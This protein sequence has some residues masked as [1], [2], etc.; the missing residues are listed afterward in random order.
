MLTYAIVQWPEGNRVALLYEEIRHY[1]LAEIRQGHLKPGDR[2]PSEAAL[3][4]QF[5]VSR[6]T[7]KKALQT[8]QQDG[9]VTR[10]R[11]RGSFVSTDRSTAPPA[12]PAHRDDHQGP[13]SRH[14]RRI[15]FIAPDIDDIY[16][17]ELLRAIENACAELGYQLVFRRTVGDAR[18]ET[19]AIVDFAS[20]GI[21]GIIVFPIHGEFYN[22]E[23]LR[24]VLR[25]FPVVLV[26]RYLKGIAVSSVATD[27]FSAAHDLTS[28]LLD[29]DHREIGF[30]TAS[31]EHTSSIEDRWQG[32]LAALSERGLEGRRDQSLLTLSSTLPG[33]AFDE[34]MAADRERIRH[35]LGANPDLTA[36]IACEYPLAQLLDLE[37]RA[38]AELRP[39][40]T[41]A[42]FDSPPGRFGGSPYLHVRQRQ[43]EIGRVAV[44]LL[45][46]QFRDGG[47]PRHIAI[48]FDLI[49]PSPSQLI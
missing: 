41:I 46:E 21:D 44:D 6:I 42:C 16:G 2:L 29:Q 48:P 36:F 31:P 30:V 3:A 49:V 22:H 23:L 7:S 43:D 15:G 32:F 27:N 20:T 14:Q 18:I 10:S 26:D 13:G 47:A 25:G 8:L 37:L 24:L 28:A 39:E 35:F 33:T 5:K 12:E 17:A 40:V 11:G 9:I 38:R 4:E 34:A 1:L 19:A 45:D